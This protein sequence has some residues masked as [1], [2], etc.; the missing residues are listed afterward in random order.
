MSPRWI[1][2]FLR[3]YH[4]TLADDDA[5]IRQKK[6]SWFR[7]QVDSLKLC[8]GMLRSSESPSFCAGNSHRP[9]CSSC[10][11]CSRASRILLF[12]AFPEAPNVESMRERERERER[13][14]VSEWVRERDR[15][16]QIFFCSFGWTVCNSYI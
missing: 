1:F 11:Q 10:L 9:M 3:N 14:R 12:Q 13:E 2:V 4:L 15:N 5:A 6:F 16:F 7:N 8:S